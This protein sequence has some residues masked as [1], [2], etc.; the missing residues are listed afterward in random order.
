MRMSNGAATMEGDSTADAM[1]AMGL[2]SSFSTPNATRNASSCPSNP[3]AETNNA[4]FRG[5]AGFR[6]SQR[7]V[8]NSWRGGK[9]R[10][11][12]N[13]RGHPYQHSDRRGPLYSGDQRPQHPPQYG[14]GVNSGKG[15]GNRFS[16]NNNS[17]QSG[18]DFAAIINQPVVPLE[19]IGELNLKLQKESAYICV[20]V[21]D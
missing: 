4:G 12:G 9:N 3:P 17:K 7:G 1:A 2:P 16:R 18:T 15:G 5:R 6:G 10:G 13:A 21:C 20:H 14:Y 8:G 19:D 11:R